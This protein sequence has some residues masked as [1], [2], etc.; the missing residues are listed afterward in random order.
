MSIITSRAK[1]HKS[2]DMDDDDVKILQTADPNFQEGLVAENDI[3]PME[4]EQTWP[5]AEELAEADGM[6]SL[7]YRIL[8][9][10]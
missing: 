10:Y 2:G 7:V 9:C 4:G 6:S 1:I 3:D 8:I 5:T